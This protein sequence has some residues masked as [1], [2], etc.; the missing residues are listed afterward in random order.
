MVLLNIIPTLT[1]NSH[2]ES[3]GKKIMVIN[4]K[5]QFLEIIFQVL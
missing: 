4:V 1:L 3:M 2:I 5:K